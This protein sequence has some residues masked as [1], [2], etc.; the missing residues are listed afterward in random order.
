MK[1]TFTLFTLFT[2][3]AFTTLAQ[4]E[5]SRGGLDELSKKMNENTSFYIEFDVNIKNSATGTDENET[6]KG[7]V[8]EDKYYASFGDNTIISNS[9]KTWTV[10]KEEKT[11]YITDAE[12]DD[13]EMINPKKLMTIWESGFKNKYGE[14]TTMNGETVHVIYLYPK[15]AGSVDY[16][17][18]ILHISKSP[19]ELKK[20]I[21]KMKDGTTMT[22]RITKL[23]LNT[24]IDDSKFIYDSMQYSGYL[25]VT[26]N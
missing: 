5:K 3:L 21:I 23:T 20:V 4:D 12:E 8:K 19:N 25:E 6:G 13:D 22:Y 18:I 17:Y 16:I 2:L 10:V 1:L 15:S 11:V 24:A 14:E 26:D 7:W 9:I